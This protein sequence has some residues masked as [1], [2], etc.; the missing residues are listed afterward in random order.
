MKADAATCRTLA[1][2][3]SSHQSCSPNVSRG[4]STKP[5]KHG[6]VLLCQNSWMQDENSSGCQHTHTGLMIFSVSE[7]SFQ[8]VKKGGEDESGVEQI[9]L[10]P[11]LLSCSP[12]GVLI[13]AHTH[14]HMHRHTR[15]ALAAIMRFHFKEPRGC[16]GDWLL[17]LAR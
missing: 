14:E 9:V 8:A 3:P 5:N 7:L 13:G 11:R 2:N 17:K 10:S 6:Q 4:V 12:E 15:A 16:C 1:C